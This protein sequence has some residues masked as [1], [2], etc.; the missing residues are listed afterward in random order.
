MG[1]REKEQALGERASTWLECGGNCRPLVR[2]DRSHDTQNPAESS[3]AS[4]ASTR[5]LDVQRAN[6]SPAE[7]S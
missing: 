6:L 4:T 2:V 3:S 7:N 5:E 1:G